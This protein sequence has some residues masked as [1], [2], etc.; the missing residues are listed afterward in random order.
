M[1]QTRPATYMDDSLRSTFNHPAKHCFPNNEAGHVTIISSMLPYSLSY[2]DY[3]IK[4][5]RSNILNM[6]MN[7]DVPYIDFTFHVQK[8]TDFIG[9][10][11]VMNPSGENWADLAFLVLTLHANNSLEIGM[12]SKESRFLILPNV[13]AYDKFVR[14]FN[15]LRIYH[16]LDIHLRT[17]RGEN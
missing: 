1:R 15:Y 9:S 11:I 13:E 14:I 3:F 5:I 6:H 16:I 10:C 17:I 2:R 4:D 8:S 12:D 7:I